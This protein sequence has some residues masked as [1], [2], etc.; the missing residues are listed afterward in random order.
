M[1]IVGGS[2]QGRSTHA[3]SHVEAFLLGQ[4][5]TVLP[6]QYTACCGLG[7]GGKCL[8][9]GKPSRVLRPQ[10]CAWLAFCRWECGKDTG[11][12]NGK[13]N[14]LNGVQRQGTAGSEVYCVCF[15]NAVC[16]KLIRPPHVPT[17]TGLVPLLRH[18]NFSSDR[19]R[20]AGCRQWVFFG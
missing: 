14:K 2:E 20:I 11:N 3:C 10:T 16:E 18:Q 13:V 8:S 4:A 5:E 6:A 19:E 12:N 1:H 9:G 7:L 17:R 15:L